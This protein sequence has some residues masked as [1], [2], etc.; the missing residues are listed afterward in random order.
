[1]CA[2]L[3]S[4]S[5]LSSDSEAAL[6]GICQVVVD[7]VADLQDN[8][9]LIPETLAVKKYNGRF[10][11]GV[12]SALHRRLALEAAESVITLNRLAADKLSRAG[13]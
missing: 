10:M 5:W 7:V 11:V 12:S 4:L 8:G 6:R 3:T 1:M 9:G 2:E 13:S